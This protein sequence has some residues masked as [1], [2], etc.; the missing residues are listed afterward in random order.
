MLL[1]SCTGK[2]VQQKG[3]QYLDNNII[4]IGVNLKWGGA[5]TYLSL[6]GTNDNLINNHDL[7]RQI[8]QSYYSGPSV[9]SNPKWRQSKLW[10]WNPIQTGDVCRIPGKVIEFKTNNNQIYLKSIP[11]QWALS[12]IPG[13][14]TFENRIS[15]KDNTAYVRCRLVNNRKDKTFYKA[16]SQELPAMYNISRLDSLYSYT[17]GKPFTRDKLKIIK[18]PPMQNG[19]IKWAHWYA[20]ENWAANV[21]NNK[22]GV[23]IYSPGIYKYIGGFYKGHD[24]HWKQKTSPMD[25]PCSYISPLQTDHLDHN[26]VYEYTYTL[27]VGSLKEIRDFVYKV[28]KNKNRPDY[29]FKKDRQHWH[30]KGLRDKGYPVN[31][32]LHVN[33]TN[34]GYMISPPAFW[35]AKDVPVLYIKAAYNSSS[36]YGR[37]SWRTWGERESKK[38]SIRFKIKPGNK[39]HTYKIDLSSSSDYKGII[40]GL[41]FAPAEKSGVGNHV[42]IKYISY[43]NR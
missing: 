4:K 23:G 13:D 14:C 39:Y 42:K 3:I 31:N 6:S 19:R 32:E 12:N 1:I 2:Y 43:T 5:I 8:Q 37:V 24:P 36:T 22:W 29:V 15:L 30:Y 21:D 11:M 26:I 28:G 27:I 9:P 41:E 10:A 7:G 34:Q 38:K 35:K 40:T 33:L 25:A 17:G 16:R 18:T 20:T